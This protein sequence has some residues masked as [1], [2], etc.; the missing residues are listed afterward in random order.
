[1]VH[2]FA[3]RD[4]EAERIGALAVTLGG[5]WEKL[6]RHEISKRKRL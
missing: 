4:L 2:A 3:C 5:S 1:L 6:R